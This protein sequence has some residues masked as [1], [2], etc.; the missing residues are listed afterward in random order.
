MSFFILISFSCQRSL[1]NLYDT[2]VLNRNVEKK[3]TMHL[4]HIELYI[5]INL[6]I[7]ID[8]YWDD[9]KENQI[10]SLFSMPEKLI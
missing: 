5:K 6:E 4:N 2:K 1:L 3:I 7:W 9:N 8:F 10:I